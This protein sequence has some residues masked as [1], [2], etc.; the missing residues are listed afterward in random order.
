MIGFLR[1]QAVT[2][3]GAILTLDVNG[4]G[5]QINVAPQ[6]GQ[7][8]ESGS[9]EVSVYTFMYI[10]DNEVALYG[11]DDLRQRELFELFLEVNGVGPKVALAALSSFDPDM[12]ARAISTDDIALLSSIPGV[13]KKTA[14]RIALDLKDKVAPS[15]DSQGAFA[16]ASA[17]PAHSDAHAALE[18]MGFSPA[19]IQVALRGADLTQETPTIIAEALRRL[20]GAVT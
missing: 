15:L 12:L 8:L 19:E 4:V 16:T 14:Q 7:R 5:F 11:F 18:A 13:G 20:G 1:G 2:F 9:A 10:R 17:T 6:V 3:D